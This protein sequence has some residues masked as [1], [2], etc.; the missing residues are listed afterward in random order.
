MNDRNWAARLQL[1]GWA[2]FWS[3]VVGVFG[4][5]LVTSLV[6]LVLAPAV[7]IPTASANL[8]VLLRRSLNFMLSPPFIL[9]ALGVGV[10]AIVLPRNTLVNKPWLS[11]VILSLTFAFVVATGDAFLDILE[12]RPFGG[13]IFTA[14]LGMVCIL[15]VGHLLKWTIKERN[16]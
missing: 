3:Y 8:P 10:I 12:R 7:G 4:V 2:T 14:L 16:L 1:G 6:A 9:G 13:P 5:Q 15:G 11:S